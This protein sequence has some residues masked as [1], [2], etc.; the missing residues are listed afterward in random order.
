MAV[1]YR[2]IFEVRDEDG[3]FV[4]RATTHVRDWLRYKLDDPALDLSL[5]GT[6]EVEIAGIELQTRAGTSESCAVRRI[7]AYEGAREDGA[8]V[9]T[10]LTAISG[11]GR[12]WA[13][14]DLERWTPDHVT[15]SW[16]PVAPGLVST[17][18]MTETAQR[19]NVELDRRHTDVPGDEANALAALVLDSTRELPLVIVSYERDEGVAVAEQ[20]ARELARRLAGVAGVY[21]LGEGAVS[22][23]SRAMYEAVGEGMDVHSGAIRTYLPGAGGDRD[24]G[25]RHRFIAHHKLSGRRADLAAL[26]ITP[27]LLRRAVEMP[28]PPLW[29][30]S[31]RALIVSEDSED[32]NELLADADKEIAELTGRVLKLEEQ[33]EFERES[34]IDL[35]RQ[36]DDQGRRVQFLRGQVSAASPGSPLEPESDRFDPAFCSEVVEHAR[37]VLPLVEFHDSVMEGALE[38]DEHADESW[39]K[40]AWLAFRALQEYAEAKA[41]SSFDGDFKTCCEQSATDV[42]VPASW[43]ARTESKQT[44]AT[45]RF[46][47]LRSL[48]VSTDVDPSGR[49][50]MEA[51]I[52]IEPGGSPAPRIHFYDD[53]RRATGKIHIGWFGDHLDS[54]AK[55]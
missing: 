40:K 22:R 16:I 2:S 27:P 48:P 12:S 24:F 11:E 9:K 4:D 45:R 6:T 29:R 35:T 31:A 13:W 5:D 53:T 47:E 52:K 18:L 49:V 55:S 46:A 42:V 3:A 25:G 33:L 30:S 15:S 50:L 54:H 28:P 20:R 36:V 8:Q 26:V 14:V 51:H 44:M 37:A 19:G 34:V 10:T 1:I 7:S 41:A 43:V 38:L 39:A 32:F 23:F 17:L 21:V